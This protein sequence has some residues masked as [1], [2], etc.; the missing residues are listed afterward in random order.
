MEM[1]SKQ[2]FG[3]SNIS[4]QSVC[5]MLEQM[6]VTWCVIDE[7]DKQGR[8]DDWPK[9]G[10]NE[11][12][13]MLQKHNMC[14]PKPFAGAV[15]RRRVEKRFMVTVARISNVDL[16]G[17]TEFLEDWQN[18]F[19]RPNVG[20]YNFEVNMRFFVAHA[21]L[22]SQFLSQKRIIFLMLSGTE[23]GI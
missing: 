2:K 5:C 21:P 16:N 11:Q 14:M 8:H 23:K 17:E 7:R 18:M 9:R 10:P 1:W 6:P 4:F 3:M 13:R 12:L 15:I 20:N 22:V 19:P